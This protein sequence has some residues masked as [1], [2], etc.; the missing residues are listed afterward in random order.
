MLTVLKGKLQDN[1]VKITKIQDIRG[2]KAQC[3]EYTGFIGCM[4]GF[5]IIKP[6]TAVHATDIINSASALI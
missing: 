5:M 3:A 1:K 4:G 2:Q 6:V